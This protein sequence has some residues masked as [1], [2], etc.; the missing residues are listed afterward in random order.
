MSAPGTGPQPPR[1]ASRRRP[2]L[3]AVLAAA[4]LGAGCGLIDLDSF[5]RLT[6]QMPTRS[7]SISTQDPRWKAAPQA[8]ATVP[9][10]CATAQDCCAPLGGAVSCSQ[11]PLKCDAG[12]CAMEFVVEIPKTINLAQ[13]VPEL[14]KLRGS[15]LSEILLETLEYTASS[16]L[17]V[18]LPAVD[19]YIAPANVNSVVG[20]PA[21][22]KIATI[23]MTASG[24]QVSETI[25]ISGEGQ[26]AF[27]AFAKD[28]QT[29]FNIIATTTVLVRSGSPPPSG[30][31]SV[32]VT[33][34]VTAKL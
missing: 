6:F 24:A 27:S 10:S 9:V 16:T 20:N 13:E 7:F 1:H 28:F 26:Q 17:N 31:V 21:A 30:G 11:F 15:V 25:N 18:I 5:N 32:N 19:V 8:F 29:P 34:K 23:P 2:L 22:R 3:L 12:V 14:T 33:G 4:A